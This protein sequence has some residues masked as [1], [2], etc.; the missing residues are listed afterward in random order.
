MAWFGELDKVT[1]LS[2]RADVVHA[3]SFLVVEIGCVD[4]KDSETI[5]YQLLLLIV[6]IVGQIFPIW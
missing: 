1:I 2:I 3:T 6:I 5:N 4:I